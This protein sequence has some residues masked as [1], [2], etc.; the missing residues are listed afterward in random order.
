MYIR[1][2][3][4]LTM[5]IY[6]FVVL[7]TLTSCILDIYRIVQDSKLS[8]GDIWQSIQLN[9][10]NYLSLTIT[11]V[12]LLSLYYYV[13]FIQALNHSIDMKDADL[14]NK[15]FKYIYRNA[16]VFILVML[17]NIFFF[18]LLTPV[19]FKDLL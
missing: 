2:L 1:K 13:K 4:K 16:R 19:L 11:I 7:V 10:I 9:L 5:I 3:F 17:L 15:S 8:M 14:F 12:N 6:I 18:I